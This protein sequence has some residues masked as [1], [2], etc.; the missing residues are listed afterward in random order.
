MVNVQSITA[1][2]ESADDI[3]V[4]DCCMRNAETL[5]VFR[6]STP[7]ESALTCLQA[8]AVELR[9]SVEG[10]ESIAIVVNDHCPGAVAPGN[11]KIFKRYIH[12]LD[13][14]LSEH[15]EASALQIVPVLIACRTGIVPGRYQVA[16][17]GKVQECNRIWCAQLCHD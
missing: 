11:R 15:A 1:A 8:P 4:S 16:A 10:E 5:A 6:L 7:Q 2:I 13:A 14:S 17:I 9:K 12:F 3:S